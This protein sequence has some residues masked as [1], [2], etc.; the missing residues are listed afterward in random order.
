MESSRWL[1]MK[2]DREENWILTLAHE[3]TPLAVVALLFSETSTI[4]FL[5][6]SF[7]FSSLEGVCCLLLAAGLN[8][9]AF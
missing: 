2:K 6:F 4:V 8:L 7:S 5:S 9:M 3:T 1:L